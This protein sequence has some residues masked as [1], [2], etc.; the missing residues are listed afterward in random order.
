MQTGNSLILCYE[1]G[2]TFT[3]IIRTIPRFLA[4]NLALFVSQQALAMPISSASAAIPSA[5]EY[6]SAQ[7]LPSAALVSWTKPILGSVTS[8]QVRMNHGT[9]VCTTSSLICHVG[10][11]RNGSS[12]SFQVKSLGPAGISSWS[13]SSPLMQPLALDLV[14]SFQIEVRPLLDLS[15]IHI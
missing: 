2:M 9:I 12:Y 4:L 3:S 6:I 1:T 11:L 13:S 15:L 5:P 10:G 14:P 8:Y 7:A